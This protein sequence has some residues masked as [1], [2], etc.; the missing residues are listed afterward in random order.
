MRREPS[1]HHVA[2]QTERIEQVWLIVGDAARQHGEPPLALRREEALGGEL[3]TKLLEPQE[4]GAEADRLDRK[5]AYLEGSARG[6]L[7]R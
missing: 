4:D 3:A 7:L 1:P 6:G 5:C 2:G